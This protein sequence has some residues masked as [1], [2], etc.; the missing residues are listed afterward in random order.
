MYSSEIK[1]DCRLIQTG[2]YG[3]INLAIL[4][5]VIGQLSDGMWE[6]SP[7]MEGYWRFACIAKD[8]ET[9]EVFI[10]VSNRFAEYRWNKNTYNSFK[11]KT[12]VEIKDWFA[13]K[14]K[15]IIKQEIKDWPSKD[16]Q[17]KRDCEIESDYMH[18]G[19]KVSD[20]Y[21]AYDKLKGRC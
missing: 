8:T 1:N 12:E 20:C 14:I 4:E 10:L 9:N 6:N 2:L 13:N 17:W 15:Q 18:D 7:R 19:V 21:K 3:N 5:S 11:A 16:F